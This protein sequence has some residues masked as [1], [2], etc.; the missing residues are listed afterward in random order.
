MGL[1]AR[2]PGR[3]TGGRIARRRVL[4]GALP[5]AALTLLVLPQS[6][7]NRI[8]VW[9]GPIFSPFHQVTA[10][11]SLDIA[12]RVPG[13]AAESSEE[14]ARLRNQVDTLENGLAEAAALLA[15]YDRRVRDLAGIRQGL[16]GLPCR[17]VPARIVS[18]E[19]SGGRASA[20]LAEGSD[21]GVRKGGAV[22]ARQIDRGGREALERGE[23]VL[24]AA[25]L[26][27]IVD[28]VG[29]LMSTVR[30]TTDPRTSLMVQIVTRRSGR[31]QAGP[32]GVA[33]GTEDG[34]AIAVQGIPRT[35]DVAVG[36]FVVTSP[37]PESPLPPYLIVGRVSRCHLK[38]AALFYELVVEPRVPPAEAREVYVL[39]PDAQPQAGTR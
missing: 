27:G 12:D 4:L 24:T 30:L 36:D 37:S 10:A 19:V 14:A 39:A 6:V 20:R 23:P 25:G 21:K 26:V 18:P 13:S 28:E 33:R 34:T 35:S 29:P 8:R 9:A 38:P 7:S 22:I 5:L 11:W 3:R 31:W 2:R 17:L 32:E 15:E 16:D 1:L